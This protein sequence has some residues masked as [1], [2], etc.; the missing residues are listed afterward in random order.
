MAKATKKK[1]G[2][3]NR[4]LETGKAA[5]GP[6]RKFNLRDYDGKKIKK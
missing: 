4:K 3:K 2:Y 1:T 6:V 5:S